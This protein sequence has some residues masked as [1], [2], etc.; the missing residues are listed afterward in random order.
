MTL[1][2]N[3]VLQT[4]K[5]ARIY[6]GLKILRFPSL[7]SYLA[8]LSAIFGPLV[9]SAQVL[10]QI[11]AA[12]IVVVQNDA[13]N[14][15]ASVTV[16]TALSINDF[17]IRP[18]SN[19]GDYNVQIGNASTDDVANGILLG[20][21]DQNGRDNGEL[22]AFPGLNYGTCSIDSNAS[23][24]PGSSGEYWL[25]TFQAPK[26]SEYNFNVAAA[27]F[28]YSD[29]WYG[30]WLNNASGANGGANNHLIGHPSLVLGNHVV[31]QGSGKTKVDLRAFGLDA[32]SNA[33][34][35]VAGGK[36]EANFAL[37]T[38]NADGT[39]T[40]TCRDDNGG[41]EQDYVGFVCVPITN[42][43]VVSGRFMGDDSIAMQSQA[44]NVSNSGNGTYHLNI[45]GVNPAHGVL[46][47]SAENGASINGD[48]MV[49]YQMSGDG[50]DIQTRDITTGFTPSLQN[51]PDTDAVVSFV[52]IPGPIPGATALR[53]S[54]GSNT[55]WDFSANQNWR[56]T[57][58]GLTNYADGTRTIL[59]DSGS[60]FTI[61]LTAAVSPFQLVVSNVANDYLIHGPGSIIGP[62][63]LTK[64]G[65][66]KLTLAVT[67]QYTDDTI[68]SQ[69]TLALGAKGCIPGGT[70]Y[71][72]TVVDGTL[73][74]AGF[75]ATLNNLSGNGTVDDFAA[76]GT[77]LLT[78]YQ[79]T[80]TTFSGTLKNTTGSLALMLDG[81]GVLTLAGA[82]TFNGG[83]TISNGTLVV[84]GALGTGQV[85]VQ[86][87]GRL[88]GT[89]TIGGL[90]FM[91]ANS[92]L[93]LTAN[94]PL[95]T[96][97]ITLNGT[98][99]VNIGSGVSLT[100][101]ATYL[102]LNHGAK[103][104]SGSFKLI[105]PPGLQANGFTASL[106]DS[107]TQLQLVVTAAGVT[108]T[109]ADVRHVVILMNENRSFDHYF[110]TLRGVRGFHDRNTLQ[111]TNGTNIFYQPTGAGYELP[112]HTTLQCL[113]DV[114][115]SWPVTH[116]T[117]NNGKNDGWVPNKGA[118]SMCYYDRSDLPFYYSL[119]EAFTICDE[120]HCSVLS[121]TD[122][123]RFT[124]MTGT[125]DPNGTGGGPE[126]DNSSI[127]GGYRWKTYP[128][129]LQAAGISWKVY[130]VSGNSGENILTRFAAYKQATPG[131]PLY[132]RARV[133][134]SSLANMISGFAA[135]VAN[136]TLPSVSWIVGTS[137]YSEH[138]P[139]SPASGQVMLKQLL[140]GLAANPEVYKSSVF[141]F[142]YDENDGFFDHV[143]PILPPPGTPDE[144]V[145]SQPIGL[146]IRVPAVVVS[147]WSRGGRV[148][149]QVFD[150]T[151]V[152]RF[153]ET[154]TGVMA[155]NISAWR[156]QVCGDLTSAF[157]FA[158]P[159][160]DYPY[161]DGVTAISCSVGETPAVP[162][163]QIV[164]PQESGSL[165]PMPLPYQPNASCALN[166]AANTFTITMTNSGA[167][168]VHFGVYANAFRTDGAW[169][170]D[171][172]TTS[173][174]SAAFSTATTGG[175]YD[176]SCYGPNGFQ[177]RFAGNLTA[178]AQKIE[179]VSILN[180][181]N[182]GIKLE[183][184]NASSATVSFT[185]TNGYALSSASY[186]VPAHTTNVVNVG[187][188]TNNGFY[189]VTVTASADSAFVRRFLGRVETFAPPTLTG[190]SLAA[191]NTFQFSFSGPAS[192]PYHVL[193]TTNLLDPASWVAVQSGVFETQPGVFTETNVFAHSARFYR[194][195]SP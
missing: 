64:Q 143:M 167:A 185:V 163:P 77:P 57:N 175:N 67:N 157:D 153:L 109:I 178:D 39:W 2:K 31:D 120:Y 123:N 119:V 14:T 79:T 94:A 146:G 155:P 190:G 56:L 113:T 58:N 43:T 189:D 122:P 92:A 165:I 23:G 69:G 75:D 32:R 194:L 83:S 7:F 139:Y 150:H 8:V 25:A 174:A 87:N 148:C 99:A 186:N 149:S 117:I 42:H 183:L 124:F 181:V 158:H 110:G 80:N 1:K 50:W 17:R 10:H 176:F 103:M 18:G 160:L 61:N 164:P 100:N 130:Q 97:P 95:T 33:V 180:P 152:L 127:P 114:N 20:C 4:S 9:G 134:Y 172:D 68:I 3:N 12:N 184:A 115:H 47:I 28:P 191:N 76:G 145:G 118:E 168:S 108:G 102:L 169:P 22:A 59:D 70:G 182:G 111:I 140:D 179:A 65:N 193:A 38:T 132:D 90:V 121:S 128:E 74:V 5:H 112:F 84:N 133:G 166:T 66:G 78:I 72:N 11:A 156:R 107:G 126:I 162:S 104:G 40:I 41:A 13:A 27:Y 171:V 98:I 177:R 129:L 187:S 48:N 136:N 21:I 34:L 154:W 173:S 137:S 19:R 54:G 159:D 81:G 46:I 49:C 96:G 170:F 36:N 26:N 151:S 116:T 88:G 63:G 192:Q 135:D 142:N 144:F 141:I 125:I 89:G 105:L 62:G 16:S 106:V 55:N 29:G 138:P 44:F 37:S 71:G 45:P 53:W 60:N 93:A 147:P 85:I 188:E 101:P 195:A 35:I 51:L 82:N 73:D 24:S 30:G 91:A 52:Y 131:N 15:T 161:L 6:Q 86:N